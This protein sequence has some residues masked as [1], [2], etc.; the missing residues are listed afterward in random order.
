[1]TYRAQT[2]VNVD[3]D[4]L[5]AIDQLA[6]DSGISRSMLIDLAAR[7]FAQWATSLTPEQLRLLAKARVKGP[8]SGYV[9]KV[10][11]EEAK[12][13]AEEETRKAI[14]ASEEAIAR[15]LGIGLDALRAVPLGQLTKRRA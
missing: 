1:M 12:R 10:T 3:A 8:V 5:T 13:A 15:S 2:T 14:R 4:T 9:R 11:V 6:A 7:H